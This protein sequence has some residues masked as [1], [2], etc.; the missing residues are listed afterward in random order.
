L[1]LGF[2]STI[3]PFGYAMA[4]FMRKSHDWLK[5]AIPWAS[6]SAAILGNSESIFGGFC[7]KSTLAL[8]AMEKE[9][10]VNKNKMD[11]MSFFICYYYSLFIIAIYLLLINSNKK[12]NSCLYLQG[13]NLLHE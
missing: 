2:A 7:E 3:I 6:F 9:T 5:S 1:F 4:G 10:I 13:Y 11:V 8:C 12:T